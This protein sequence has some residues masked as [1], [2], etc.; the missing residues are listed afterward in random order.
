M[1]YAALAAA[2][3]FLAVIATNFAALAPLLQASLALAVG[4]FF[5][6]YLWAGFRSGTMEAPGIGYMA[7]D[8]GERPLLFW[9][10]T[11][12]NAVMFLIAVLIG[13]KLAGL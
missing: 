7:G 10:C 8:R 11:G 9:L 1:R 6:Y 4:A 5:A 12:F 2:A 3:V 13:A